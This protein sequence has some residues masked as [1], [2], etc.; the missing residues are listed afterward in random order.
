MARNKS[1]H[2]VENIHLITYKIRLLKH[3]I[4]L[5]TEREY[6]LCG[7]SFALYHPLKWRYPLKPH[8]L[9]FNYHVLSTFVY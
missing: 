5:I 7:K 9:V 1:R 4:T 8:A 2:S 3:E 6:F